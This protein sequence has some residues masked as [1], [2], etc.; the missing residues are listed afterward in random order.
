MQIDYAKESAECHLKNGCLELQAVAFL[1]IDQIPALA[2]KE[3]DDKIKSIITD[4]KKAAGSKYKKVTD[5]QRYAVAASL[6]SK[7][8]TAAVIDAAFNQQ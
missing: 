8:R 3:G 2:E 4:M 7:Y 5:K 1:T 6:L